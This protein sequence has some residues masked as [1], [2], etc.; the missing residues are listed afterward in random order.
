MVTVLF[1]LEP[2]QPRRTCRLAAATSA[3]HSSSRRCAGTDDS[4][5]KLAAKLAPEFDADTKVI[6]TGVTGVAVVTRQLSDQAE[7]DLQR[8]DLLTAPFT[9]V[10]L[11][12]VF[13]S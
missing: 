1:V 8:S 11:V 5:I 3:R 9:F 10:A 12:I 4:K 7:K 2:P 13:G 6:S